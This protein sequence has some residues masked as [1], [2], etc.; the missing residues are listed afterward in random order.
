MKT[1]YE[2]QISDWEKERK[3]GGFSFILKEALI[4]APLLIFFLFVFHYLL[5]GSAIDSKKISEFVLMSLFLGILNGI[6]NFHARE[7]T[8]KKAVLQN[9]NYS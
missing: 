2:Q 9:K 5:G 3:K 6:I 4:T 8:Y 1:K 7:S